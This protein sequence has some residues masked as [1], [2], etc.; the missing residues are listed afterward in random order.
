MGMVAYHSQQL[1]NAGWD[2]WE[3]HRDALIEAYELGRKR[4]PINMFHF[5]R[6]HRAILP[7]GGSLRDC[8]PVSVGMGESFQPVPYRQLPGVVNSFV[9]DWTA[10]LNTM[11][12]VAERHFHQW[13]DHPF[14]DGNKRH[15]R[16]MTVYGCGWID[17]APVCI[18]LAHKTEYLDALSSANIDQLADI[19]IKCQVAF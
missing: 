12:Q 1:E 9:R 17:A 19:F 4:Q 7:F 5:L 15:A 8:N 10:D 18:T 11:L 14:G 2:R 6:W 3:L 13:R 16:L